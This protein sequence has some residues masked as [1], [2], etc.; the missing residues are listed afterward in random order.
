MGLELGFKENEEEGVT[1]D[2]VGDGLE[3]DGS[4]FAF[5]GINKQSEPEPERKLG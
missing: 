2:G 3:E 4:D 1:G 5:H